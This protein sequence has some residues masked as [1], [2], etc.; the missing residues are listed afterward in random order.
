MASPA[1]TVSIG[2]RRLLLLVVISVTSGL[3]V[4]AAA[5]L[6][7]SAGGLG[8]AHQSVARCGTAGL[9][10]IQNLSGSNVVSVTVGGLPSTC[11]SS[12]LQLTVY[13]GSTTSS[14]SAAVPAAGGSVTVTLATAIAAAV[15]ERT[16][17]VVVGP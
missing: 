9:S 14:G 16:D 12:T 3:T 11:G 17:L 10:V 13:N 15:N 2:M 8:A 6:S 4:G 5:S 7:V 1:P